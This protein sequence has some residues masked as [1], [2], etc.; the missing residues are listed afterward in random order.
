MHE[1]ADQGCG[2]AGHGG[3]STNRQRRSLVGVIVVGGT[4]V[5]AS[6][7]WGL[8]TQP[9]LRDA[10]WGGVPVDLRPEYTVS[11]LLAAAGYFAYTYFIVVR[12]HPTE[13]TVAG[14]SAYW[15]FS[16]LYALILVPSAMWMPLTLVMLERP[17]EAVWLAIRAVLWAV[18]LGS[19]ALT[20]V[21]FNLRPRRPRLAYWLAETG[22]L[23][24]TLHTLVLDAVIWPASFER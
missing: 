22:C 5:L 10:L 1:S 12:A 14:R 19:L 20:A 3:P 15:I 24:F 13:A 11:M 2:A 16:V 7:A 6:Y 18:A 8:G 9:A 21:L 23:V 17:S 4:A